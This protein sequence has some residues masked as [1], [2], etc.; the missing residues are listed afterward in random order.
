[1]DWFK[2][3]TTSAD[4][5]D[6]ME[7]EDIFGDAG[8]NVFFKVLEIYGKEFNSTNGGGDLRINRKVLARKLGKRWVKVALILNFY[9]T[10]GRFSLTFD[11][12]DDNF[13]IINIPKFIDLASNWVK[14]TRNQ[15]TEAPTDVPTA[16]EV[17]EEVEEE[18]E[19]HPAKNGGHFESKIDAKIL[20]D[21]LDCCDQIT[22]LG[23]GKKKVNPFMLVQKMAN[24]NG[25]PNAILDSLL[26]LV[27]LW[28]SVEQ[29]FPYA[30]KIFA[31]KNGTY[32]EREHTEQSK[33]FKEII[34]GC[35][36]LRDLIKHVGEK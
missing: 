32:T 15:P 20:T 1:M 11:C 31:T 9:Q 33:R 13:I 14:R 18:K 19:L 27:Q 3:K 36:S 4:D 25:H 22:A 16:I 35:K 23:N 34:V 8:Y 6:I 12:D 21:I 17:E 10:K 5:P 2:H 28:S 30:M 24:Q 26:G 29:P 7:A